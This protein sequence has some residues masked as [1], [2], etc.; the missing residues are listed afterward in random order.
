MTAAWKNRRRRRKLAAHDRG[1]DRHNR[2]LA[3]IKKTNRTRLERN[4]AAQAGSRSSG[5]VRTSA[6][7]QG[8]AAFPLG[9]AAPDDSA[10]LPRC[11]RRPRGRAPWKIYETERL[12]DAMCA[13]VLAAK[14]VELVSWPCQF[15][16]HWHISKPPVGA[17]LGLGYETADMP[18]Q[19]ASKKGADLR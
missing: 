10:T 18:H 1:E 14:D 9:P 4:R 11:Q 17:P 7:Q 12:A 2:G 19:D 3:W 8:R 13:A 15:A 6:T 5:Q 16:D